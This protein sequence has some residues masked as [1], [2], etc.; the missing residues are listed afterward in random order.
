M[1]IK[2]VNRYYAMQKDRFENNS[3]NRGEKSKK[4]LKD[5]LKY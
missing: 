4:K 5:K 1:I 3:L 2:Q